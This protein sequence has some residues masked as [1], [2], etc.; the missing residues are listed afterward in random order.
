MRRD[1]DLVRLPAEV[2]VRRAGLGAAPMDVRLVK[3]LEVFSKAMVAR[4][5]RLVRASEETVVA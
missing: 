5:R 1:C 3:A 4:E 2:V